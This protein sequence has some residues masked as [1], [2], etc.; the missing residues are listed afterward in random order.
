MGGVGVGMGMDGCC[1]IACTHVRVLLPLL[2]SQVQAHPKL[3]RQVAYL[4]NLVA[5]TVQA[6][7]APSLQ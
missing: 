6:M 2:P 7:A 5:A 4:G 3:G 1:E